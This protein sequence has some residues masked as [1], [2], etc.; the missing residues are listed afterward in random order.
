[1]EQRKLISFLNQVLMVLCLS[2]SANLVAEV[3]NLPEIG[4]EQT[5]YLGDRMVR[6]RFGYYEDEYCSTLNQDLVFT[7]RENERTCLK[8]PKLFQKSYNF[9]NDISQIEKG[10]VLCPTGGKT[11]KGIAYEGINFF[12]Y[13]RKD[14]T[15]KRPARPWSLR[16]TKTNKRWF[17][18]PN[19][20]EVVDL[21]K[22]GFDKVFTEHKIFDVRVV[23]IDAGQEICGKHPNVSFSAVQ[24]SASGVNETPESIEFAKT[25][26]VEREDLK[27]GRTALDLRGLKLVKTESKLVFDEN[28][29]QTRTYIIANNSLQRTIEY[30]G[31][32]GEI[33][34]FIYSEFKNGMARDA[35]TREFAID[36]SE[37]NVGA[38]KGA[39]F[40]VLEATNATITYKMIRH[41]PETETGF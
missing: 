32:S 10:G 3:E 12:G 41:F 23:A 11:R 21:A 20:I 40:E 28:F 16:E 27:A 19:G 2:F 33:L 7:Y 15:D 5:V 31:R 13:Q 37:S 6:Q 8:S 18:E 25:I 29:N 34:N 26:S 35:F 36:L 14:G 1:M 30:A 17:A 9:G 4:A 38:F 22:E 39:V 24:R